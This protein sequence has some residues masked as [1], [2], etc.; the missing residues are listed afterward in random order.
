MAVIKQQKKFYD[1]RKLSVLAWSKTDQEDLLIG[2][3][4]STFLR[5]GSRH[6]WHS[7]HQNQSISQQAWQAV[8]QCGSRSC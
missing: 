3:G 1:S 7:V 5:V 6:Q 4:F 8:K 2:P